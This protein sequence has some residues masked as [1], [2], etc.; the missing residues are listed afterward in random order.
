MTKTL[1]HGSKS[2]SDAGYAIFIAVGVMGMLSFLSMGFIALFKSKIK[3]VE[4]QKSNFYEE[5]QNQ[6]EKTLLDWKNETH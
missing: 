2:K 1:F 5:L 6:N 3:S 4:V